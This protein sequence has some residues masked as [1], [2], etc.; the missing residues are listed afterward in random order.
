V[1]FRNGRFISLLGQAYFL[2]SLFK[3]TILPLS[4]IQLLMHPLCRIA[5]MLRLELQTFLK[6]LPPLL[7]K[8]V[9]TA[10]SLKP[11][12][13][14]PRMDA[15]LQPRALPG[16]NHSCSKQVPLVAQ[17]LWR[18][19]H[20]R[21]RPTTLQPIHPPNIKTIGLVGDGQHHFRSIRMRGTIPASSVSPTIQYQLPTVSIASGEPD[22]DV[23]RERVCVT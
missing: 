9:T 3:E 1:S 21:Q 17:L 4:T 5:S 8:G 7:V 12:L 14:K 6:F 11:I 15:V 16:E 2:H 22:T 18:N 10:L 13:G 23:I 19:L 20:L